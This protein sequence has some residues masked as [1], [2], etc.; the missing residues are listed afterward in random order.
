[1]REFLIIN[2]TFNMYNF[3]LNLIRENNLMKNHKHALIFITTCIPINTYTQ[4]NVTP[5]RSRC[6]DAD[7]GAWCKPQTLPLYKN[8]ERCHNNS[9]KSH[10][11]L[12]R[13][14]TETRTSWHTQPEPEHLAFMHFNNNVSDLMPRCTEQSPGWDVHFTTCLHEL[15]H[16]SL[17]LPTI[18][19][20]GVC[21]KN[22]YFFK[23]KNPVCLFA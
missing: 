13:E 2:Y 6:I 20:P 4:T 9:Q 15:A 14:E 10:P 12:F 7:S 11:E 3:Q 8:V 18:Y 19:H 5:T 1:M 22:R 23:V 16:C 21:K 17:V